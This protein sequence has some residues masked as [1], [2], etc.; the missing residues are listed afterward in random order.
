M[1]RSFKLALP[2][3]LGLLCLPAFPQQPSV[4]RIGVPPLRSDASVVSVTAARDRLVKVLNQHKPDKRRWLSV[5]AIPLDAASGSAATAEARDKSCQFVLSTHLTDLQTSAVLQNNGAAGMDYVPAY[6]AIVEYGLI[7]I[8]DGGYVAIGSAKAEDSSLQ[9]AILGAISRLSRAIVTDLGK[10]RSLPAG[11]PIA[12]SQPI[13][14]NNVEVAEFG[15][16][17]CGW[18]PTN[19]PHADALHHVCEYASSI[20]TKMPNFIC[21]QAASRY[22][23][24][25]RIP[26]DMITA[27]VR[28][29]DGNESYSDVKVNGVSSKT[30]PPGIWSTGEFGSDNLHSIF[31]PRN[32]ARFEFAGENISGQRSAWIFTYQIVKQ[33]D[34]LWRLHGADQVIAPP[35]G[36]EL[37]VDQS[38]SEVL[39]FSSVAKEI[40]KT[41]P[42]SAAAEQV[43]YESVAFEDG[44]SFILP[45]DFSVSTHYRGEEATRNSVHLTSCHKFRAKARMVFNP[46]SNPT[47]DEASHLA[48]SSALIQQELEQ[49]DQIYAILRE[50]ALREDTTRI[51][52]DHT[53]EL[54]AATAGALMRLAALEKQRQ[55]SLAT[56]M[57]ST[58]RPPSGAEESLTTLRVDVKLVPVSV[59]LR[60]SSGR[61]VGNLRKED[62]QLFDNGKPQVIT[63]FSTENNAMAGAQKRELAPRE[64][65]LI[66]IGSP[67]Q[68]ERSVAY[69][70]DDI[71]TTF[72]DLDRARD[73]AARLLSALRPEDRAAVFT[74]SSQVAL[75]FTSDRQ[76][77]QTLLKSLRPHSLLPGTHCP[78]VSE[79]MADLIVNQ[80]DLETLSVATQDAVNCAFGGMAKSS[81][82][83]QRAEQ[84]A[85]AAAFEILNASSAEN[86]STLGVL[87]E[88]VRRTAV[89]SGSR[90][91]VIVS[92]GFLALTPDA[93]QSIAELIDRA[94]RRDIVV[95]T[96][97]VR[98]LYTVGLAPNSMRPSDPVQRVRLDRDEALARSDV[99]ADLAYG[100]GGTFF[101]NNNDM[102]EGFRRTADAPEYVYV[103]GFSPQKLDGKFHKLKVK[104]AGP[105]KLTVQARQGYYA[106]RPAVRQ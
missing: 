36:G 92:P 6:T 1:C 18:L 8:A 54:N 41:F 59:V 101:H 48:A 60:D 29:E 45:T 15:T 28:Y 24:N 5:K 23:G 74:T 64:T 51:E 56:L 11:Q 82:E 32:L 57:A 91:I 65:Q 44:S 77:L 99:M 35:Y 25:N 86:Q 90:S 79:Y 98:G 53:Q 22:R 106:Q 2:L 61:A 40:P 80:N 63:S 71:H 10:E 102:N 84:V 12:E 46:P 19:I 39:R 30:L 13:I 16:D 67:P 75:D 66:P 20:S 72:E 78:P 55:K 31:D 62:F 105:A 52:L 85:K 34:P 47:M 43:G 96:L 37:W 76:A 3:V 70:F 17:P 88:V 26:A 69:V 93:R 38:T 68:V 100:T 50:Q 95:N 7:R 87:R 73:A 27:S 104:L 94:V 97:D 4:V 81:A 33:N 89:A 103:L 9:D 42:M 49:N 58:K 14:P 83:L 21:D